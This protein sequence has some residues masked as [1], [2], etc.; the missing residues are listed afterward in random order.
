MI[1]FKR[2][3]LKA[4]GQV[5]S[6]YRGARIGVD[7]KGMTLHHSPPRFRAVLPPLAPCLKSDHNQCIV[8]NSCGKHALIHDHFLTTLLCHQI[9]GKGTI[10]LSHKPIV[11]NT[12]SFFR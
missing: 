3:F 10:T 9:L 4:L 1:D 5:S 6:Q 11:K 12:Y 8:H 7:D 2:V